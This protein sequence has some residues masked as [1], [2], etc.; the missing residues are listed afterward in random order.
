[1]INEKINKILVDILDLDDDQISED[2]TPETAESWDSM[3]HLRLMTA[4]EQEFSISLSMSDIQSIQN[5]SKLRELV[6]HHI[7]AL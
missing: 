6:H 2:L 7:A 1:M 4:I 3:K 5:V